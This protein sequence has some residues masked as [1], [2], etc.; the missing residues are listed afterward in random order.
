MDNQDN[1]KDKWYF[2]SGILTIIPVKS[3]I[4]TPNEKQLIPSSQII[5]GVCPAK[6]NIFDPQEVTNSIKVNTSIP[7]DTTVTIQNFF[8]ISRKQA[9][10][11]MNKA[12]NESNNVINI[13]QNRR[14]F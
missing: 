13:N 9:E 5:S 3:S 10:K 8:V 6:D 11:F 12:K 4:T 14:K 2:F 1:H 7:V